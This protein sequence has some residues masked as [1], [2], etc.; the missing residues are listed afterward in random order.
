M[1]PRL[2]FNNGDWSDS[3]S[4][5]SANSWVTVTPSLREETAVRAHSPVVPSELCRAVLSKENAAQGNHAHHGHGRKQGNGGNSTQALAK[6]MQVEEGQDA[7]YIQMLNELQSLCRSEHKALL[8]IKKVHAG[9]NANGSVVLCLAFE[10]CSTSLFQLVV[11][12]YRGFSVDGR[13][14]SV[15]RRLNPHTG[16]LTATAVAKMGELLG[17]LQRL[18]YIGVVHLRICPTNVLIDNEAGS[19]LA[20]FLGKYRLMSCLEREFRADYAMGY[21]G[22]AAVVWLAPELSTG[23]KAAVASSPSQ[24]LLAASAANAS[25]GQLNAA[26]LTSS[27]LKRAYIYSLGLTLFFAMTGQHLFGTFADEERLDAAGAL[28]LTQ[29][30]DQLFTLSGVDGVVENMERGF[31]VNMKPLFDVPLALDLVL[32]MVAT[33]PAERLDANELSRHPLFFE[34]GVLVNFVANLPLNGSVFRAFCEYPVDVEVGGGLG[35]AK[36]VFEVVEKLQGLAKGCNIHVSAPVLLR[37]MERHPL[38]LSRAWDGARLEGALGK[39]GPAALAEVKRVFDGTTRPHLDWMRIGQDSAGLNCDFIREY[40]SVMASMLT[41]GKVA[42]QLVDES[43]IYAGKALARRPSV[44]ING[45]TASGTGG[46]TAGT[47]GSATTGS[48]S[49]PGGVPPVVSA[50][51]S[52]PRNPW[53]P[54][55]ETPKGPVGSGLASSK[56][57]KEALRQVA[58]ASAALS[59]VH[60]NPALVPMISGGR[61]GYEGT[62]KFGMIV[63][64]NE[65]FRLWSGILWFYVLTDQLTN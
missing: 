49:R 5:M 35:T 3:T 23:L 2:S 57:S 6:V 36:T 51:T 33:N 31:A 8:S 56:A 44:T 13:V 30:G 14:K 50:P 10:Q 27:N 22:D 29:G 25:G 11:D 39:A 34:A 47:V 43:A 24:P 48:L 42:K 59:A 58:A 61:S 21:L 64:R 12:G 60:E 54:P 45:G 63:I 41:L 38:V 9:R 16:K 55:V 15:A 53:A 4:G 17:A 20:D 7:S 18:H 46:V 1:A 19:K 26:S 32:R 62:F 52:P 40:Y 37:V 65:S 28:G